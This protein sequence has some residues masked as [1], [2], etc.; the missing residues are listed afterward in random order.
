MNGRHPM[1]NVIPTAT[2]CT[3]RETACPRGWDGVDIEREWSPLTCM[4][5]R[6]TNA[7]LEILSTGVAVVR[8]NAD[9]GSPVQAPASARDSQETD[10]PLHGRRKRG[11]SSLRLSL[12]HQVSVPTK[13]RHD[14]LGHADIEATTG[15]SFPKMTSAPRRNA[16]RDL[17]R[18]V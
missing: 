12:E 6:R 16:T 8:A 11:V 4:N 7:R 3:N 17:R 14:R 1:V 15:T 9:A 10:I 18:E 2:T 13:V 5:F